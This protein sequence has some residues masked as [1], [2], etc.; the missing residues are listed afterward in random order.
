VA[1]AVAGAISLSQGLT[2]PEISQLADRR[3]QTRVLAP[4]FVVGVVALF[5]LVAAARWQAG[6]L[7][8]VSLGVL[9]GVSLP[10]ID[11]YAGP[12]PQ[13][14]INEYEAAARTAART[15]WP[16]SGTRQSRW[17]LIRTIVSSLREDVFG[18]SREP[19]APDRTSKPTSTL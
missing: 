2:A 1:S 14:L 18:M 4:Q 12:D 11:A 10:Q 15:P 9:V 3:G 13:L 6:P 16:S 8:V 17:C 5:G 19:A 7:A